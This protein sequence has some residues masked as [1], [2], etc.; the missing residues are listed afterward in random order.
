MFGGRRYIKE[1]KSTIN[2]VSQNESMGFVFFS[3]NVHFLTTEAFPQLTEVLFFSHKE[4]KKR[5]EIMYLVEPY[6]KRDN[7][8]NNK[9]RSCL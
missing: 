5:K 1:R 6:E 8:S 9:E 2:S 3:D 4:L 7:P